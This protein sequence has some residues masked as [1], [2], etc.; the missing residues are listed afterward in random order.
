MVFATKL[1]PSNLS[2][3]GVPAPPPLS[4][5]T[6]FVKR[7]RRAPAAPLTVPAPPRFVV[8]I[9]VMG[10]RHALPVLETVVPVIPVATASV[11]EQKRAPLAQ[12]IVAAVAAP[13]VEMELVTMGRLAVPAMETVLALVL[14]VLPAAA[15]SVVKQR[16][17]GFAQTRT[18]EFLEILP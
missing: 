9:Y 3:A 1:P 13:T 11:V 16:V 7:V 6:V 18:Q 8:T 17:L 12:V 2:V 5:A 15:R 4:V 14:D 10:Q